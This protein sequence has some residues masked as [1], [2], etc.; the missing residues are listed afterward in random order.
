MIKSLKHFEKPLELL[1]YTKQIE[2]EQWR[3]SKSLLKERARIHSKTE[4]FRELKEMYI[5]KGLSFFELKDEEVITWIDTL[6]I[7]R[8]CFINLM[9]KGKLNEKISIIMEY[10]F[11]FGNFMRTDYL[12]TYEK[13]AIILEFGMF[14]Q[15]EKRKEERY[16][17]KI[18]EN[19]GHR[20][21][22]RNMLSDKTKIYSYVFMYRPEYDPNNES[23]IY[24]NQQYNLEM[25]N[26]FVIF[27][28]EKLNQEDNDNVKVQLEHLETY[29]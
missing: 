22:L 27:L 25:I 16:T 19:I 4:I 15:D 23:L 21:I 7:L 12:I 3:I 18:Q 9:N 28:Q 29:R 24:D 5:K 8:R 6:L 2:D 17:K 26:Q 13:F 20:N 14:N 11:V 10:P 1:S